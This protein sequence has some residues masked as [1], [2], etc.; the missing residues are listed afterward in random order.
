M[1]QSKLEQKKADGCC[2]RVSC[3]NFN[4]RTTHIYSGEKQKAIPKNKQTKTKQICV[5]NSYSVTMVPKFPGVQPSMGVHGNNLRYFWTIFPSLL[6][7]TRV[8]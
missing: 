2:L 8:L 1:S 4:Q 5:Y 7:N 6:I 3:R